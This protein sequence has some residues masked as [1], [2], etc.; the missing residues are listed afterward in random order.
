MM[1]SCYDATFLISKTEIDRI[2]TKDKIN[3]KL[4]LM[5][6]KYCRRYKNQVRLISETIKKA[7]N[8]IEKG[9]YFYSLSPKQKSDIQS[10]INNSQKKS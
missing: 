8:N 9:N 7:K 2:S 10:I 5:G 4:H 6:C 1:I 3:L